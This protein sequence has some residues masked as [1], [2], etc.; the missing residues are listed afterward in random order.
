M[1]VTNEYKNMETRY[2]Y[3]SPIIIKNIQV[4]YLSLIHEN[5]LDKYMSLINIKKNIEQIFIIDT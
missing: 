4:K 1:I 5:K 2:K 3:L